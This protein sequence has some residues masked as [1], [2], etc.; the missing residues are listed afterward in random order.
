MFKKLKSFAKINL[1]LRVGKKIKSSR[2]HNIQSLVCLINL[3]DEITIKTNKNKKD[4]IKFYGKFSKHIFK[5]DTVTNSISILKQ[6]GIIDKNINYNILIKKN[7]PVFSGL[8]GGS[9]NAA[10]LIKNLVNKEKLN[11]TNISLFSRKI[12]S[13]IKLFFKTTQIFQKNI[14]Q[15]SNIKSKLKLYFIIIYPFL[16]SSTKEIYSKF[17]P[18]KGIKKIRFIKMLQ[19]KK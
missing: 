12:G 17:K 10:F 16:K 18:T 15:I 14:S 6:K 1:Y 13:D 9:S 8:G 19:K 2:L 3:F 5:K 11:N 4:N 7:I